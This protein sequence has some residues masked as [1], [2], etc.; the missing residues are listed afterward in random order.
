MVQMLCLR[1]E[2][3]FQGFFFFYS[4]IGQTGIYLKEPDGSRE[5]LTLYCWVPGFSLNLGSGFQLSCWPWI[6][7]SLSFTSHLVPPSACCWAAS[8]NVFPQRGQNLNK[9]YR[10]NMYFSNRGSPGGISKRDRSSHWEVPCDTS[11]IYRWFNRVSSLEQSH[12]EV[13]PVWGTEFATPKH[14]SLS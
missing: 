4:R 1:R 7:N 11:P 10:V 13:C 6:E 2:L 9:I 12:V 8:P 3:E 14:V 5:F